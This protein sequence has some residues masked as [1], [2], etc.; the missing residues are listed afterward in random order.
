MFEENQRVKTNRRDSILILS[1]ILTYA[2]QGIGRTEL[3]FK[4]GIS[5]AQTTKYMSLLLKSEL[6]EASVEKK[7]LLY[8]TTD[9]GKS[10]LQ[11]SSTLR[12]LMS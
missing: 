8:R 4:A 7:R 5:S 6:L 9:K 10:F 2:I 12:K 11:K 1:D 3:M